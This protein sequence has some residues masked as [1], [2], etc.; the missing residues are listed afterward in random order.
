MGFT[1]ILILLLAAVLGAWIASIGLL[2]SAGRAKGHQMENAGLL[3]YIGILA[4]P[5]VL[6]LYVAALPD[7]R[8]RTS[9]GKHTQHEDAE[10]LPSI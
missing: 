5:V 8:A 3:W 7:K 9:A 6:G 4:S 1:I 10:S 2:I